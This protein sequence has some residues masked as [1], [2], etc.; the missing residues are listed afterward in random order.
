MGERAV[1]SRPAAVPAAACWDLSGGCSTPLTELRH[2][3]SWERSASFS[4]LL[5]MIC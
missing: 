1:G 4:P 2:S 3:L 5:L